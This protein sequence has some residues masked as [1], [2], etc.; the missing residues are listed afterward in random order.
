ME[1]VNSTT[2]RGCW[3]IKPR[4]CVGK[5]VSKNKKFQ[6]EKGELWNGLICPECHRANQKRLQSER[7][8]RRKC[9][10]LMID[11]KS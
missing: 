11:S 1:E 2:C 7:R 4:A 5:F 8:S 6:D 3:Q 10:I 9:E